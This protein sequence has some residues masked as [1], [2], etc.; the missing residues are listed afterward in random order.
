MCPPRPPS[1]PSG[2]PIA[3]NLSRRKC[4]M[5]APPWPLRQNTRIWSTKLL[6]SK[7]GLVFGKDS[8]TQTRG[9]MKICLIVFIAALSSCASSI[10][11][12]DTAV[13]LP[14]C[15]RQRIDSLKAQPVQNP[16]ATIYRYKYEG[17]AV[18]LFSAPCCD[19][20]NTLVDA[21]C[22]YLCAPSGGFTGRGDGA[23]PDFKT[24]ATEETLIWRD[25]R[26]K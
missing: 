9:F 5:P 26:G 2:P 12:K 22:N 18:Y 11:G 20:Y 19:Q 4:L 23:C 24:A 25:E 10:G 21:N 8:R 17:K 1:P 7:T 15:I 6:F 14:S 3:V 13:S 16:P